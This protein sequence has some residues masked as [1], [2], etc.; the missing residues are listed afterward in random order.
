MYQYTTSNLQHIIQLYKNTF[1]YIYMWII[2]NIYLYIIE[3]FQLET[4]H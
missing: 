2:I 1:L 4:L 3:S